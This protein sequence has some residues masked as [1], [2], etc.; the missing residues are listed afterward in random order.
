MENGISGAACDDGSIQTGM[1]CAEQK[2][3][4]FEEFPRYEWAGNY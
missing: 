2:K 4:L 1:I 3:L